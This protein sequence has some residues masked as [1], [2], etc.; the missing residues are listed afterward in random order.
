MEL[1]E[2]QNILIKKL[3]ETVNVSSTELQ[4]TVPENIAQFLTAALSQV[5]QSSQDDEGGEAETT[6]ISDVQ[7]QYLTPAD[8]VESVVEVSGYSID[9]RPIG[10]KFPSEVRKK[11]IAMRK[12]GLKCKDIAK[13][14]GA[15]VSGVQK[16]WERFLAT[17]TIRDRKPSTYAGRP[18][19]YSTDKPD[20]VCEWVWL[21]QCMW[22]WFLCTC[23]IFYIGHTQC[24]SNAMCF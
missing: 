3:L 14:L 11:I 19:K 20:D 10:V 7:R 8:N 9:Q 13:D 1:R 2:E 15:S 16:V 17:G 5:I 23:I 6:A 22:V 24:N 4:S 12:E 18:R 21:Y